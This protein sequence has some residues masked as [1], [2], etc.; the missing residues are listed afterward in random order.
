[1]FYTPTEE[2]YVAMAAAAKLGFP[3]PEEPAGPLTEVPDMNEAERIWKLLK[4]AAL[5]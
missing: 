5:T 3:P 1:M 4:D 2:Q